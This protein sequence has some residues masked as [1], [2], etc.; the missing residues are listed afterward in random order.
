VVLTGT[1]PDLCHA[2]AM[3]EYLGAR[4]IRLFDYPHW[5]EPFRDELRAHAER[6]AQEAGLPIEF[7]R[8]LKDFRKEQRIKQLLATR[9]E[10]PGLV[11]IFSAMEPCPSFRPWHDKRSG[12]TFL[13]PTE[14]KCLHY[15][16]YFIDKELG[17]CYLR[18]PTWAP[19]RLQFY[20]NGHHVLARQ[21]QR[22]GIVYPLL[23]N[24]FVDIADWTRAQALADAWEP[25][26]LHRQLDRLAAT[27]CPVLR[28][29]PAGV[30][31]SFMQ[32]EYATDVVFQR[33]AEFQP[34]YEA[35]THTAIHAVK[36]AHVATFLG[37]KL[38][39]AYQDE[40]GNDFSTRIEGTRIKHA[41]GWAAIK[42]SEK[43]ALIARL[44]ELRRLAVR[45]VRAGETQR[46]VAES[47]EVHPHTVAK[48]MVWYR[49]EGDA[50]LASTPATGRPPT[51][52][53]RQVA[54]LRRLIIGKDPCQLNF[55]P[56]LWTLRLVGELVGRCFGV[57]LHV[58]TI[59][60]LLHRIGITPQKPTRQ[61]FQRD[62]IECDRWM[63]REFPRIVREARRRQAVLLFVDETGVRED[64]PVGRTWGERGHRPV[65]RVTGTRRRA[66]V[67][68]AITPRGRLWFRCFPGNLNAVTY[69]AFL[70][71]LRQAV[72]K[73]I[74]L[75]QDRH[76]AHV[77]AA[78]CR[79]VQ[80]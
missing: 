29:F 10:H 56:A 48:W 54:Q 14:A 15:Y 30:H 55:G 79:F 21:L 51:L 12:K 9:G 41:R 75:I 32:V 61:A 78:T 49:A 40:I 62:P 43:F 4:D 68:S 7:I 18:V 11:H 71:A 13:K 47:L 52:S 53:H 26:R 69:I 57:V 66:N 22:K 25:H 16:F 67:I 17:L 58:T 31:W 23:D 73:P 70:T 42:R 37:R 1:L 63:T 19:F 20:C 46:A 8:R 72:R 6:L 45:R 33:Q 44:Q 24:A 64:H 80:A 34:L 60:R 27:Y 3:A 38:T 36:P 76:P 77:A 74:I 5:A 39:A 50:G 65:V 2:G 59:A 28:H 35:L